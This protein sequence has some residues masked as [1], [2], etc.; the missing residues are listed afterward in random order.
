MSMKISKKQLAVIIQEEIALIRE[1]E[2]MILEQR[3]L[4]ESQ[5][6]VLTELKEEGVITEEQLQEIIRA[7]KSI[8]SKTAD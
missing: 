2:N 3:L 4:L 6:E 5:I 8:A 7:L 1:E